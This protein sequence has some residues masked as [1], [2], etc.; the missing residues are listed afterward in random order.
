MISASAN[1]DSKLFFCSSLASVLA[2]GEQPIREELSTDPST[3]SPIGYSQSKW[4]AEAICSSV[5]SRDDMKGRVKIMRIGQLCGDT[6][7]GRWSEKEGW[8][9]LIR[10]AVSTGSLPLIDEVSEITRSQ[11]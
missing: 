5:E 6:V 11:A 1:R 7:T 3:A 8:P 9:L 2:G 10:T 4:V